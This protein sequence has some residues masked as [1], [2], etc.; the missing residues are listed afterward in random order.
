[1]Y[2]AASHM[3]RMHRYEYMCIYTYTS[4]QVPM[5]FQYLFAATH[6]INAGLMLL[7]MH[8]IYMHAYIHTHIYT[9]AHKYR[10]FF[11]ISFQLHI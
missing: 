6:I 11:N 9:Q 3:S 10:W 5:V 8:I 4:T 2:S 1:M 7:R